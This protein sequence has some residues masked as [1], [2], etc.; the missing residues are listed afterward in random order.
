VAK[1]VLGST[2]KKINVPDRHLVLE[3][4]LGEMAEICSTR[5]QAFRA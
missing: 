2:L 1:E 5:T 4:D 3:M